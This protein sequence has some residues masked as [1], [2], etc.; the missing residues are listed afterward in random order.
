[1]E[2][3]AFKYVSR[4]G[5]ANAFSDSVAIASGYLFSSTN[6]PTTLEKHLFKAPDGSVLLALWNSYNV[7]ANSFDPAN[8]PDAV[9]SFTFKN[10]SG[11]STNTTFDNPAKVNLLTGGTSSVAIVT[12][13]ASGNINVSNFTVGKDPVVLKFAARAGAPVAAYS[14]KPVQ[15][16]AGTELTVDG[17]GFG[18]TRGTSTVRFGSIAATE[19]TYWSDTRVKCKVPAAAPVGNV[20]LTVV[21]GFGT[22]NQEPFAVLSSSINVTSITPNAGTQGTTV[23]V[24]NLAGSNFTDNP[25]VWIE[26]GATRLDSTNE[27][28]VSSTQITC[29]ITPGTSQPTGAYDVVVS[30]STGTQQ[31]RLTGGFTV[32][33]S[34]GSC[35]TG[36]VTALPLFGLMMG[37]MVL[38]GA[39]SRERSKELGL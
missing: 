10:P 38:V 12:R 35:G 39:R 33:A 29:T 34:S 7:N 32:N 11:S 3:D 16:A 14:V 17:R 2:K 26:Q 4:L 9:L 27:V 5:D 36:A 8:D 25:V 1:V 13:D 15:G 20:Q 18:A 23:N 6:A 30:N 31:G 22:S 24:T 37:L 19:Y 28:K 21:T